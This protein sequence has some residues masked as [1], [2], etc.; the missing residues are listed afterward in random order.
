[1]IS[2]DYFMRMTEM[3]AAV[4]AKVL[5]NKEQ[6]NLEAAQSELETAAKSIVGLDLNLIGLMS[7]DNVIELMKS[8]DLYGG[9]CV[10][11]ADLMREYAEI[12]EEKNP[13]KACD[14]YLKS[15]VLYIEG[16]M[17]NDLPEPEKYFPKINDLISKLKDVEFSDTVKQR[18]FK[19]YEHS[20]NFSKAEDIL[21]ELIDNNS[22]EIFANALSFY[23]RLKLK[24]DDELQSGNFS[25][26]EVEDG[27]EEIQNLMS[28]D[29]KKIVN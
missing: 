15:L 1:M 9:R 11:S 2:R 7:I 22:D 4:I 3:L 26:D 8:S 28:D 20:G 16:V 18:L 24:S 17:S 10:I 14:Y 27:L 13:Q 19:Y 23:E 29:D 21:F 5:F 25:R 6:K 12:E